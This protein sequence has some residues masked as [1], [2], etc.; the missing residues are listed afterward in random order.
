MELEPYATQSIIFSSLHL[1]RPVRNRIT[2]FNKSILKK[3][4]ISPLGVDPHPPHFE[5]TYA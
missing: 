3:G 5:I 4:V 2:H 1:R